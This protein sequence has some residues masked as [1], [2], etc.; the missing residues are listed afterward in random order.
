ML[1]DNPDE[2]AILSLRKVAEIIGLLGEELAF[3]APDQ[4]AGILPIN[5]FV[6]DLEELPE[7]DVPPFLTAGL[8]V[9]RVWLDQILDG[10]GKFT[11]ESIR[12]LNLWHTWMTSV[13]LAWE[14]GRAMPAWPEGWGGSD[15]ANDATEVDEPSIRLNL[16]E[17][18]DFCA[19]FT[20]SPWS[21][22]KA[23]SRV[24]SC[25]RKIPPMR[26]R[27]IR[28]FAPFTPSRAAPASCTWMQCATWRMI[29]NPFLMRCGARG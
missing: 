16:A 7:R 27:S 20:V 3:V 9:A 25:S 19:N 13:L 4:D 26:Q 11:E 17:D 22:C 8:K 28:F 15:R 14:T 10:P 23:L 1:P 6:M 29:W 5:R 24:S 12:N 21:C 2:S 18:L